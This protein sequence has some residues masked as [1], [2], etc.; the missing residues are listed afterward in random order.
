M[1]DADLVLVD[2]EVHT[3]DPARPRAHGVAFGGGRI[4]AVG[5]NAQAEK[6]AGKTTEVV[7][8]GGKVVVPG[9]IDA[10]AHLMESASRVGNVDLGGCAPMAAALDVL[11]A[12]VPHAGPGEW[13]VGDDW[14]ESRWPEARYLTCEDLDRASP[15]VPIAAVR[16]DRHMASVNSA[17]LG[18][19]KI[20]LGTRGFDA[21]SAGRPTGVLK[22]DALEAMWDVVWPSAERLAR[23]FREVATRALSLGITTVH[24]VV[25]AD[26]IRAY[27]IAKAGGALPLRATLMARDRLLPHLAAAGLSRGFGDEWLRLG[28]VK[29]FGDGSLGARTAALFQP[30]KDDPTESG[31]LIHPPRE[32]RDILAGIHAAGFPSAVHAIGD[33]AIE[34]V[35]ETIEAVAPEAGPRHR[36][37]HAELLHPEH[38]ERMARN[39]II[40]SCQPNFIGQWSR[41]GGMYEKRLGFERTARNNP[42][43]EVLEKG[44][45]LAFGSDGMPYG[46]MEGIHWAVNAPFG[47]QGI[48]MDQAVAA[49][50]VGGAFAAFDETDGGTL[51]VGKRGDA[52]ILSGNAWQ[53]PETIRETHVERTIIAGRVAW[54]A[55]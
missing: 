45:V 32:L 47:I 11:R 37:E 53:E 48:T 1:T 52:V 36:I 5:T 16:V 8:L 41:P 29:V 26:E 33:R 28:A 54:R 20:P 12:A 21:T 14:D 13:V 38:V 39:G 49:Y 46:P 9:F 27:Q 23:N 3:M 34:L 50:T 30:Y 43:R 10:H 17:A 25:G 55:P 6:W 15:D 7:E 42:Y 19:L 22:E 40:A 35:I 31:M 4:V 18:L 44:V 51:A 24:D 2:G